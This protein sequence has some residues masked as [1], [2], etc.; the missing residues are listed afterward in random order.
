MSITS[1]QTSNPQNSSFFKESSYYIL[2]FRKCHTKI[3]KYAKFQN[4]WNENLKTPHCA[5]E[6][7]IEIDKKLHIETD[8]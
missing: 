3:Y 7:N 6:T 5:M 1:I 4:F 2:Y 8:V